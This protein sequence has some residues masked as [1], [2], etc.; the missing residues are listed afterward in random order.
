MKER[1]VEPRAPTSLTMRLSD[2]ARLGRSGRQ[3]RQGFSLVELGD[4][5]VLLTIADA[6]ASKEQLTAAET[7]V[8]HLAARGLSSE[9]IAK[10]RG[11][12]AR[13]VANQLA[14][15]YRK[16]GVSG[17]RELRARLKGRLS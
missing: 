7:Q 14:A 5:L 13:T 12:R 2:V 15:A 8:A 10:L 11:S 9:R 16:L 6:A 1:G 3:L 17:R 4:D